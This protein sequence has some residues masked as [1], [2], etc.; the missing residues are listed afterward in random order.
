MPAGNSSVSFEVQ[1]KGVGQVTAC[2]SN[3]DTR[4]KKCVV[5]YIFLT[6]CGLH[7]GLCT[8]GL[9]GRFRPQATKCN[10]GVS[11]ETLQRFF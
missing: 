1:A 7:F 11:R 6:L 3:N 10:F 5:S 9:W 4:I 8:R 2:L